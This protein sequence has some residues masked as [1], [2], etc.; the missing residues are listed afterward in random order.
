MDQ[1]FLMASLSHLCQHLIHYNP[2]DFSKWA[3]PESPGPL[4]ISPIDNNPR[5]MPAWFL[6]TGMQGLLHLL[7]KTV[8]RCVELRKLHLAG[9]QPKKLPELKKFFAGTWRLIRNH[10]R[11]LR[12]NILW[13]R[14][15]RVL[16]SKNILVRFGQTCMTFG[17]SRGT[18][19]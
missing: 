13:T 4:W 14:W 11:I 16:D 18:V 3:G 15:W 10:K 9:C 2:Y 5:S 19:R 8:D 7:Q 12:V 6:I 17:R 1:L